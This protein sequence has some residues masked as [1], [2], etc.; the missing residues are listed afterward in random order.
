ML[1]GNFHA[2]ARFHDR[3]FPVKVVH[4][5]LHKIHVGVIGEQ[6]IQAGSVIVHG[7]AQVLDNALFLLLLGP[8]P[9]AEIVELRDTGAAQVVQQVEIEISAQALQRSIQAG[10][11]GFGGRLRPGKALRC[12]GERFA[13]VALY[14]RLA[15]RHLRFALVIHICR[16]EVGAA[17]FHESI[18]HLLYVLDVDA[19]L[20]FGVGQ[21]QAHA[22]KAKLRGIQ[23]SAHRDSS[24]SKA[25]DHL[26]RRSPELPQILCPY[27]IE[28]PLFSNVT[29]RNF[30]AAEER[31][32]M[33]RV[34]SKFNFIAT[35]S[36]MGGSQRAYSSSR[37]VTAGT[38]S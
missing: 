27:C 17:R 22:A 12:K 13:G 11:C 32:P 14:Q 7:K 16:V 34:P 35:Q 5:Q 23:Q 21:R 37:F 18:Y 26:A 36:G 24:P 19:L 15:Q 28:K 25:N 2:L 31:H 6:L 20:V 30:I 8:F 1:L 9:Q 4:L 33:K 38:A 3:I 29:L 10:L